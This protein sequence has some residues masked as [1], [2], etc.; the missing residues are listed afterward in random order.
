MK[1][2]TKGRY[3]LH[4]MLDLATYNT[5]EPISLK[6]VAR[7]QQISDKYLEQIIPSLN[8]AGYVRSVRGAQG[9]YL[10]ARNPKEYTVG[11]ILRLTEGDLAPVS[12]V[13]D[14]P[15]SCEHSENCAVGK[16]W[17]KINDAVNQVVDNITLADLL[18]W[19]S[20]YVNQYII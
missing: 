1:I 2:S 7:R 9:G 18:D 5:G 8:K 16:V 15:V 6:D 13:G 17:S 11:M 19:Q 4:L 3:A 12:C 10:L 20:E 14:N